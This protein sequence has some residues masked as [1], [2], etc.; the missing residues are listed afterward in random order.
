M[1][2]TAT[3]ADVAGVDE[4]RDEVGEIAD[5][6]RD[7]ARYERVGAELPKGIILHGPPGTGKT[8]LARAIHAGSTRAKQPFVV[9]DCG[10]LAP[11]LIESE[12]FGHVRGAFTGATS[13]RVG[14]FGAAN[15]GT[16]FL[17]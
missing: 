15:R 12:L 1:R 17:D 6:L 4:I 10:A 2:S 5:V 8:L 13:D 3:F 14:A 9:V 11:T 7:P 16:V